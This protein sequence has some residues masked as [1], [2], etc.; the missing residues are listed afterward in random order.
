MS[1]LR[2]DEMP[3]GTLLAA[4]TFVRRAWERDVLVALCTTE[5]GVI[6]FAYE[7]LCDLLAAVQPIQ[8]GSTP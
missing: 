8:P 4:L 7:A 6:P 2:F 3:N 5:I 1:V